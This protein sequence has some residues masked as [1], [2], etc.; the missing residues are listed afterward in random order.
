MFVGKNQLILNE[1]TVREALQ[2]YLNRRVSGPSQQMR[3]TDIWY[4]ASGDQY[5]VH[6]QPKSEDN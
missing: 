3:V 6:V 4:R 1:L 2:E 5:E